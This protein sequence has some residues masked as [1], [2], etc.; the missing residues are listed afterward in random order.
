MAAIYLDTVS[1]T[2]PYPIDLRLQLKIG[3]A[4]SVL[5]KGVL[6]KER[7]IEDL[8]RVAVVMIREPLQVKRA[9]FDVWLGSLI[10]ISK[11]A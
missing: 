1:V 5:H 3:A 7:I 10:G 9:V 4:D 11:V 8:H 2:L 6:V